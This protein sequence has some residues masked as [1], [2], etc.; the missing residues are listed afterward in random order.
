MLRVGVSHQEERGVAVACS[1][2]YVCKCLSSKT[3]TRD[4]ESYRQGHVVLGVH[5][6]IQVGA[7]DPSYC[8]FHLLITKRA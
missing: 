7:K 8:C 4:V 2:F 5:K 3:A 1:V 6:Q